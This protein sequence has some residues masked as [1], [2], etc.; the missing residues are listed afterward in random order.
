MRRCMVRQLNRFGTTRHPKRL[1]MSLTVPRALL[2]TGVR[3]GIYRV[4]GD[5]TM[6]RKDAAFRGVVND[7]NSSDKI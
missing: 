2:R 4:T 1:G 5:L 3:Y 7:D 6:I